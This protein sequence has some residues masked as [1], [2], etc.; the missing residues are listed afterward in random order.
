MKSI[1]T[2]DVRLIGVI[3]MVQMPNK[4]FVSLKMQIVKKQ[5][6]YLMI[7]SKTVM[8]LFITH[9]PMVYRVFKSK[10]NE[11]NL[12]C[13]QMES[14]RVVL[15]FFSERVLLNFLLYILKRFLFIFFLGFFNKIYSWVRFQKLISNIFSDKTNF[16]KSKNLQL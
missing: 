9:E 5:L 4:T 6:W 3:T 15:F 10:C 13:R 16:I 14:A 8:I 1:I 11:R 2:D 7:L 12:C